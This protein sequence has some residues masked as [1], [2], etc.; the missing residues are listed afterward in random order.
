M[1]AGATKS[2]PVP[3]ALCLIFEEAF[4]RDMDKRDEEAVL[5]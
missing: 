1:F 4:S 2:C 3:F 5:G